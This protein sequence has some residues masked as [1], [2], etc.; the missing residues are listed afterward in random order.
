MAQQEPKPAAHVPRMEPPLESHS[1]PLRHTPWIRGLVLYRLFLALFQLYISS[2]PS[3]HSIGVYLKTAHENDWA[4]S[5]WRVR[6]VG[7]IHLVYQETTLVPLTVHSSLGNFVTWKTL[8]TLPLSPLGLVV[9]SPVT[10]MVSP[11]RVTLTVTRA[12]GFISDSLR[13]FSPDWCQCFVSM[14]RN[15]ISVKTTP[16][17]CVLSGLRGG[18]WLT[19]HIKYRYYCKRWSIALKWVF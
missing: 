10:A 13:L 16:G 17:P 11:R 12:P 6:S 8:N 14:S 5:T 7:A 3:V 2:L 19:S 15:M 9:L 18:L 1:D 4:C